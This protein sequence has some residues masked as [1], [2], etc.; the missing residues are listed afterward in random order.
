M[1]RSR[2]ARIEA[3]SSLRSERESAN[4]ARRFNFLSPEY[5]QVASVRMAVVERNK[6]DFCGVG[7]FWK[8]RANPSKW[9]RRQ[10]KFAWGFTFE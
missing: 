10:G 4:R 8:I 5:F 1:R 9:E 7:L 6:K 3:K 2:Q